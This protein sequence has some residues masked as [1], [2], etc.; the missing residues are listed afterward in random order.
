MLRN[1]KDMVAKTQREYEIKIK[2]LE[3]TR[4]KLEKDHLKE[5]ESFKSEYARTFKDE[6]FDL[7]RRRLL[8]DED[9]HKVHNERDRI[10]RI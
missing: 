9:E 1:E 7:H 3:V 10:A 2:E 6:D 4:L 8:L 5:V